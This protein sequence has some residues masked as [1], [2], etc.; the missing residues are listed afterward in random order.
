MATRKEPEILSTFDAAFEFAGQQV[1]RLVERHPDRFVSHTTQGHW[2]ADAPASSDAYD[3]LLPG[4]MWIFHE[5]HDQAWWAE[6]AERY[7]RAIEP[8]KD[9]PDAAG[10]GLLFYHGSHRRW[11]EAMVRA[12]APQPAVVEVI[13]QAA[14]TL[15][16]RFC[17]PARC[18][19]TS[20]GENAVTIE[21]MMNVPLILYAANLCNDDALLSIGS[22]HVATSRRHLVRGDGS[23]AARAC[24]DVQ[25]GECVRLAGHGA[26]SGDS[27]WARG[28]AWAVYG[29]ATCGR[30]LGFDPWLDTARQCGHYLIEKLSGDPVPP[31]DLDTPAGTQSPRDSSAAAIA[32]AGLLELVAA[33][34][35][36][37][38][39]Q[40]LQRRYFQDAALRIL[41][42]LCEPDYLAIDD[43]NWEGILKHGIGDPQRG[44]AVDESLIWGD[45]FFTEALQ[46]ARRLLRA[47]RG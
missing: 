39:E 18:L 2:A 1:G 30:L 11:N 33:E 29:F 17:E 44:L 10:L 36:V 8:R 43:P 42:A 23:T 5:E 32:A 40:A 14:R 9:R 4:M 24:F 28:Q 26:C 13:H 15:A 6:A 27:C 34:Q 7:S 16:S 31:W 19:L 22:R 38:S 20:N 25:T 3:G 35:T 12:I 46:Q 21:D 41:A 47:K 37:G 45:F